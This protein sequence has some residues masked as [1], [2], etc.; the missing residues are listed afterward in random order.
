MR[1]HLLN[2]ILMP[3]FWE[4]LLEQAELNPCICFWE[5]YFSEESDLSHYLHLN[6]LFWDFRSFFSASFLI[7]FSSS[8]SYFSF[9]ISSLVV[10]VVLMLTLVYF[11]TERWDSLVLIKSMGFIL[12][13]PLALRNLRWYFAHSIFIVSARMLNVP[14]H[15]W[16]LLNFHE[17]VLRLR[18]SIALSYSLHWLATI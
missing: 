8:N 3:L 17:A 1:T 11:S 13:Y 14:S 7:C 10:V 12:S 18:V 5:N 15:D 6:P 9:Y 2:D 16:G 4:N